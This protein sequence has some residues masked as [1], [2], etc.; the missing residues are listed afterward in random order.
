M[1]HTND[2]PVM[3]IFTI[4]T[5][6]RTFHYFHYSSLFNHVLERFYARKCPKN[7]LRVTR[8][9]GATTQYRCSIHAQ[10]ITETCSQL[11][12]QWR[13]AHKKTD[14]WWWIP[15]FC[16]TV[17]GYSLL[18]YFYGWVLSHIVKFK[19]L[20]LEFNDCLRLASYSVGTMMTLMTINTLLI[21]YLDIIFP[22]LSSF[23]ILLPLYYLQ[24]A[25][26]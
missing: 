26:T 16:G 21:D 17:F 1:F 2:K 3:S 18:A 19:K 13:K 14:W 10:S 20:P 12:I 7:P 6:K 8:C 23:A 5:T 25:S 22:G 9:W 4:F 15:T 11:G 24:L